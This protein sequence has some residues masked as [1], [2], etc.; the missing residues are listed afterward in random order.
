MSISPIAMGIFVVPLLI[1]SQ[2]EAIRGNMDPAATPRNIVTKI[3]SVR[4]R[5]KNDNLLD[6]LDITNYLS[7]FSPANEVLNSPAH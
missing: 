1:E 6:T 7:L 5:S 3:Q 4:Y 2:K